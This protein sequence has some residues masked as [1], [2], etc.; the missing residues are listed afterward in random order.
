MAAHRP[1]RPHLGFDRVLAPADTR[2]GFVP[3]PFPD[4]LA[5]ARALA[6]LEH[7]LGSHV[8]RFALVDGPDVAWAQHGDALR[9]DDLPPWKRKRAA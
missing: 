4:D 2:E 8:A 5:A 6:E 9:H 1:W 7:E 3:Y